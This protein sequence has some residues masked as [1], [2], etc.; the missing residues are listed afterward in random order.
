MDGERRKEREDSEGWGA[1]SHRDGV[2]E[3]RQ[4]RGR[5]GRETLPGRDREKERA[6]GH[7][8]TE[9]R[10]TDER[11]R[12]GLGDRLSETQREQEGEREKER[13]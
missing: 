1:Q 11:G 10:Q 6:P 9:R 8:E 2:G 13:H 7:K 4:Q 5:E 3:R 12:E